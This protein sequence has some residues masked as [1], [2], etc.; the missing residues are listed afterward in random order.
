MQQSH[1]AIHSF[2]F[3]GMLSP[4]HRSIENLGI[5]WVITDVVANQ[6]LDISFMLY[7]FHVFLLQWWLCSSFLQDYCAQSLN[8]QLVL[9]DVTRTKRK[10]TKETF[11]I[12]HSFACKKSENWLNDIYL[13]LFTSREQLMVLQIMQFIWFG[14]KAHQQSGLCYRKKRDPAAGCN[15]MS[16]N[17]ES[18]SASTV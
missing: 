8:C 11:N 15:P 14:M 16:N 13:Y 5:P 6:V 18:L 1:W 17:C 9:W 10:V 3:L 2:R 4:A 7:H 12:I